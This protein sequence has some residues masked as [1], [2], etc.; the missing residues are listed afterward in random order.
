[1]DDENRKE[2]QKQ[3]QKKHYRKMYAAVLRR[4]KYGHSANHKRGSHKGK[5][6][7]HKKKIRCVA[8]RI[9]FCLRDGKEIRQTA[10]IE[11]QNRYA[12]SIGKY[13]N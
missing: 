8:Q 2:E 11:K 10:L 3:F 9:F 7:N 5:A 12:K 1:M 6:V 13:H 4:R